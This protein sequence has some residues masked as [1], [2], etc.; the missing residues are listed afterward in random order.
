MAPFKIAF[1]FNREEYSLDDRAYNSQITDDL[2]KLLDQKYI[3]TDRLYSPSR[4]SIK[5]IFYNEE[6]LNKVLELRE[7]FEQAGY[8]PRLSMADKASRT[9]FCAGFDTALLRTYNKDTIKEILM[10]S[11]WKV[12]EVHVMKSNNTFKI[13]MQTK[14]KQQSFYLTLTQL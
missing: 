10:N 12:A 2:M 6:Q 8:Y 1:R 5:A 3:T 13:E 9:I 7:Y 4:N 11:G 14:K